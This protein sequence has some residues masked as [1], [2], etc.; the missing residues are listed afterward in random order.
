MIRKMACAVFV[1]TVA[2]GFTFADEFTA[3]ITKAG[4]GK[5]TYQKFKKK[6]KGEKK[7]EKD[8]DPVT[9]SLATDAK[10]VT[11]KKNKETKKLE[12]GT[13]IEG[14][15]NAEIFKNASQKKGVFARITTEG[16]KVTQIMV[17]GGKKKKKKKDAE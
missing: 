10:I 14:G 8:G 15:L 12:A 7:V 16:D 5:I 3:V 4:D 2:I 1:M 13:A 17:F 11:G 6:V 9:I